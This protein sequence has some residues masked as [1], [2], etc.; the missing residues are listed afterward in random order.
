MTITNTILRNDYIANGSATVFS[1]T[2]VVLSETSGYT[3]QVITTDLIGAETIKTQGVDYTVQLNDNGLGTITFNVAPTLNHKITL[4][5]N[6]PYTQ[7]TDYIKAGTDKFP[8]ESHEK[9]LDKLTLI[10]KQLLEKF[11]RVVS[12]PKS[13]NLS[14][15][16][17]PIN[18]SNA[19][20]I[21]AI[22][23][24]GDNLTAK[25][26]AEVGLAPVSDFAKTLLDDTTSLQARA[27]LDAQQLNANLTFLANLPSL[28]YFKN[29]IT[30]ANNVA[31]PN[32]IIDFGAGTYITLSGNQIYLPAITK[33]I[34]SSG[35]WTAGSGQNGLDTGVRTANT[36]YRA[37]IVQNNST[38]A[39]DIVFSTSYLSPTIPSGYTNLGLL[40]YAIIRV[41][42]S[43]NIA[44][45]K[46]D[47][48]DKKVVLSGA[49]QI[50]LVSSGAGSGNATFIIS[51]E[52][53][54]FAYY[55]KGN[56]IKYL[57][58]IYR[59]NLAK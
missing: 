43:N 18:S 24:A 9:A 34:Q 8:A 30:I 25:N 33:K 32:D 28:A 45:A 47:A 51:T 19:N 37:Y 40:D 12:L 59:N 54:E 38:L 27:T 3:I 42:G 4:L 58:R 7:E 39:Y 6:V 31:S 5:Q 50:V 55:E 23:N 15:I 21:L 14:N 53:L 10:S 17:L 36:F 22:N 44:R 56:H 57:N 2:F 52:P 1:F 29:P 35:S 26:L 49:E 11:N 13:S 41:N 48:S 46:W 16:D 20:K